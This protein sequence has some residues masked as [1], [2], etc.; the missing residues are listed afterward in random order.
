MSI[1][2]AEK[3]RAIDELKSSIDK[4]SPQKD[5][6]DAFLRK[7]KL[8]FTYS[9]NK[10]EGNTLTY[11]QTIKLLRDFVTPGNAASGEVLDMINHQKILDI[12]FAN[13]RAQSISEENIKALHKELMKYRDQ[14]SDDGL[15]SPGQYKS[16]ENVTVRSS[17]KIHVFMPPN[18]VVS[19]MEELVS[20][21]NESLKNTDVFNPDKHPLTIATYFHQQFLNR[22]HPFS[23][24]NGRI[25]RI[26]TNLILLKNGYP[27]IFIKEVDKGEYLKSFELSDDDISPMLDFMADR[28]SESLDVKLEFMNT[29]R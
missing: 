5:W 10:L 12:I 13:Y 14:W 16:F 23:D 24:G 19:A 2:I 9:S 17:G 11:G 27:P 20:H 22:I 3:L 8:D 29:Q 18:N 15:Y 25:C 28:L 4:L 21:V 26:F 6:D 1:S 7:I